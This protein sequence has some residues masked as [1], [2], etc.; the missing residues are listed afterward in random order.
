MALVIDLKLLPGRTMCEWNMVVCNVVE[1]MYLLL[2][3]QETGC[4]G[5]H[6]SIAPSL[7]EESSILIEGFEKVRVWLGSQPVQVANLK[8]RP[9]MAVIVC[10]SSIIREE[11]H[12]VVGRDVLW[13]VLHE[14]LGAIPESGNGLDVFVEGEDEGVLL[15]VVGHVLESVVLDITEQLDGW[16][17]APIPF[18]VQHERLLEEE[19]GLKSTH[20]TIRDRIAIDDFAL[21]H[22]LA[23]SFRFVLIDMVR[24]RPVLLGNDSVFGRTRNKRSRDLLELFIELLVVQEH[25][26]IVKLLVESVLDLSD[27]ASNL[28]DVRI[29]RQGDKG[30]IHLRASRGH[31]S[32]YSLVSWSGICCRFDGLRSCGSRRLFRCASLDG[33]VR[34]P[35]LSTVCP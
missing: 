7:V 15:L 27:G 30:S 2:F 33:L 9:E 16:L 28:P 12:R 22:I 10:L 34:L 1:E 17:H 13:M 26:I 21:C 25:P 4:D 14:L 3:K 5:V 20:V 35:S 23:H 8:I 11:T 24:K 6:R 32:R 18:I 29:A 31:R 19:A